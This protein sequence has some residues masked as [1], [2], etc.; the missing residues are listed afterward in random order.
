MSEMVSRVAREIALEIL[1]LNTPPEVAA[2]KWP[3]DVNGDTYDR[4]V[5]RAER[6]LSVMRKPTSAMEK[7]AGY[8]AT[9]AHMEVDG[10]GA[11]WLYT[12]MIDAA[13][14]EGVG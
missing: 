4:A 12:V 6:I 7:V 5:S 1:E 8:N 10:S 11:G 2:F 13:L 3:D 14:A 9:M